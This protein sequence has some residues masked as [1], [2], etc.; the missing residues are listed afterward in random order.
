MKKTLMTLAA[1]LVAAVLVYAF[2]N[3]IMEQAAGPALSISLTNPAQ[4]DCSETVSASGWLKPWQE[5]VITSEANGRVTEVLV[6]LGSV[7]TKGQT[8]VRLSQDSVLADVRK[9][10]AA[11]A[12]ARADLAKANAAADRV[13]QLRVSGGL[14]EEKSAEILED[15]Q[16]AIANLA[17][18]E[19]ALASERVKLAQTTIKA[20]DDGVITARS[21]ELGATVSAG[22]V[23][24][25]LVRQQRIEWQAEVPA[26]YLS[27]IAE[28]LGV[29]IDIPDDHSIEGKVRLVAPSVS[30]DTQAIVY[31]AFPP[32]VHPRAG[33]YVTGHIRLPVT[34]DSS[35][36]RSQPCSGTG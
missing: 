9:Y 36:P 14:S 12:T 25:R 27:R 19:A 4:H 21:T 13:R 2:L 11:V 1:V 17:S 6:D 26:R 32:D 16:I 20:V 23:L 5:A 30:A 34:S 10:E 33:L 18:E 3:P 7:V 8:L 22:T 35:P 15:E 28:G 29:D 31:V 24:F